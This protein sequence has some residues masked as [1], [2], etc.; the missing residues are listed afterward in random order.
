MELRIEVGLMLCGRE[1]EKFVRRVGCNE[2]RIQVSKSTSTS[3]S[4]WISVT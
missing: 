2:G 1:F 4:D 3:E